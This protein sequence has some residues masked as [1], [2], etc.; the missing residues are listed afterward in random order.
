MARYERFYDPRVLARVGKL[1]MRAR[2]V[3]EGI[4]TGMHKSPYH[5]QSVEFLDH[6]SYVPGDDPRHIDWKVFGRAERIV[7]KKFEEE[8]NLRGH[9]LVDCSESMRYG[10]LKEQLSKYE[11]AGTLAACLAYLLHRQ[12]DSVGITLFDDEVRDRVPLS[13]NPSVL[14]WIGEAMDRME[15]RAKTGFQHTMRAIA[16]GIPSRGL[17][18]LIS[19]LF[20]PR[21]EIAKG[22]EEFVVRGHD[23][24]VFH[25]LEESELT[26]PFEG[27][28]LFEGLEAELWETP[29]V[30]AD[31]RSLRDAYLEEIE[32]YLSEVERIASS[33]GVDYNRSHTGEP[34]DAAIISLI[35]RRARTRRRR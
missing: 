9:V 17:V 29:N 12:H 24:A 31:P 8:T 5:G 30:T 11:Y 26:F 10:F 35:A 19:D 15:P 7:I 13:T 27:N 6:R 1:E 34:L 14:H 16:D 32:S 3:V 25:V 33:L 4:I 21:D 28:T 2:M 22:L 20:A 18:I 23:L